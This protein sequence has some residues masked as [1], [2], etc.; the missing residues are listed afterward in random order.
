MG[1]ERLTPAR[2]ADGVRP[3]DPFDRMLIAQAASH[4]LVLV[5]RDE[6][7]DQYAVSRVW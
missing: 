6:V 3:R 7:Y 5:S 2:N 1:G 4:G